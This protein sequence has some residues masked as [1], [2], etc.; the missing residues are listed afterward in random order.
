MC[1]IHRRIVS[2]VTFMTVH[3]LLSLLC[4][5]LLESATPEEAISL[6]I[7]N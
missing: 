4:A 1:L 3:R 5:L 2:I 6:I 7:S